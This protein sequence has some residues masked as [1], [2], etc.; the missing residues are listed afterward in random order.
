MNALWKLFPALHV[1]V[2]KLSLLNGVKT[3]DNRIIF[4]VSNGES[5]DEILLSNDQSRVLFLITWRAVT[6]QYTEMFAKC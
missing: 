6:I 2:V 3:A 5:E 4:F 1:Q